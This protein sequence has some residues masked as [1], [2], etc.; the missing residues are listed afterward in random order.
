[1]E[2]VMLEQSLVV[3]LDIVALMVGEHGASPPNA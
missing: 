1:M 2:L 3:G